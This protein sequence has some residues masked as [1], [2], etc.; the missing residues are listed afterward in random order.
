VGSHGKNHAAIDYLAK[1]RKPKGLEP[2]DK[3]SIADYNKICAAAVAAQC[4]CDAECIEQQLN[5]SLKPTNRNIEHWDSSSAQLEDTDKLD[6]AYD[7]LS[8][9]TDNR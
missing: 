9:I 8:G 4:E 6:A 7:A 5:E 3:C 1:Q 2:G